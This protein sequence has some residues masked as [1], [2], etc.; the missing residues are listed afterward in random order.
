MSWD[1]MLFNY[2]GSP[3]ADFESLPK[4]HRPDPLGAAADVRL[5]IS[6]YLPEIDW[7]DPTW[8]IYTGDTFTIEFNPGT[9]DPIESMMLHVRGRGDAL[10]TIARFASPNR[11]SL[12]DCT[13]GKLLDQENPSD[14]G[15][16]AFES[17]RDEIVKARSEKRVE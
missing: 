17:F 16:R 5:S 14:Q 9:D 12:L 7:T 1:V 6:R 13:T 15:W 2:H 3:P 8:G 4:D 11:W 10:S